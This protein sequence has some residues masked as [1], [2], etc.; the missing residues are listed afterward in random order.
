MAESDTIPPIPDAARIIGDLSQILK[1]VSDFFV[2]I[3]K[4]QAAIA[5]IDYIGVGLAMAGFL[6]VFV[7]LVM[8]AADEGGRDLVNS[9]LAQAAIKA[10]V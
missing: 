6:L 7:A 2:G 1:P 9:P 3:S 4:V 8:I 5:G 10:A